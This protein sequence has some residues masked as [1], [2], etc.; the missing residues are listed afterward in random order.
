MAG[1]PVWL[2][3]SVIAL[4]ESVFG[5]AVMLFDVTT[6]GLVLSVVPRERLGRVNA[7]M[8]FLTQGV[9][10]IGALTGGALGTTI[11]LRPALWVAA[12]GATT[13]VLWTWFSP[14]RRPDDAV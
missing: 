9:K 13:T 12:V 5:V 10:P 3:F 1:G 7:C 2:S 4:I 11:G 8:S 6:A 14:L